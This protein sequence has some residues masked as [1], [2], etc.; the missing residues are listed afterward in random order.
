MVLCLDVGDG[1]CEECDFCFG[2][3]LEYGV[4]FVIF[5]IVVGGVGEGGQCFC[6]GQCG[7]F[8][9]CENCWCVVLDCYQIEFGW[10][11]VQFVCQVQVELYVE[12]V[13]V[14]L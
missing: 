10:C 3:M 11:Y 8:V 14:D 9:W 2:E 4:V 5:Y 6:L 12:C 7:M 13:F 1:G